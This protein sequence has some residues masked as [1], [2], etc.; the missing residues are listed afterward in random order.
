MTDLINISLSKRASEVA[1]YLVL[2]G[3][4]GN[5]LDAAKFA[6]AYALNHHFD[7]INPAK[8]VM[9]DNGGNHYGTGSVDA[10]LANL[11]KA[12]Y[13]ECTTPFIYAR[14]LMTFG[15]IKL[16]EKFESEGLQSVSGLM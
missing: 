5:A 16:G 7:D 6:A 8:Y 15:L 12:I 11:L 9:P 10:D 13:P 1:D 2:T 3:L 14:N 4:F